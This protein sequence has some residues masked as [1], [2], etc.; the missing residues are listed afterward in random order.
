MELYWFSQT[1]WFLLVLNLLLALTVV[2]LERRDIGVTWAWLMVLFFL[3]IVGFILYLFFG[4]NLSR[5]KRYQFKE[6]EKILL[7]GVSA[8][9]QKLLD[10]E[11]EFNDPRTSRY[12]ELLHMNMVGDFSLYSQ[13]NEVTVYSDGKEKFEALLADIEQAEKYIHVQYYIWQNDRL[14]RRMIDALTEKAKQGVEVRVLYDAWGSKKIGRRF[15]RDFREAGGLA[16]PFFPSRIPFI[17]FKMNYRNHRKLVIIDGGCGYIGG[18]N[19]GD[20]YLGEVKRFGYWRDTHLRIEGTALIQ[21]HSIFLHDWSLSV[22]QTM[23]ENL[24]LTVERPFTGNVGA[25]IVSSGP[26]QSK[27]TI[28]LSYIKMMD[29]ARETIMIQTPYFIPDESMM[30]A[31]KMAILSGV[32][33]HLM[34]PKVPDHKMVYWASYSYLGELLDLGVNCYLYEKGF[35]HA[36]TI[37]VDGRLASVGT[38]NMDIRSYKLNFEVN[39][40]IYDSVKAGELE[41][42]FRKDM[43]DSEVLTL[44]KYKTRP[45]LRKALESFTRLLSPIL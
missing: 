14:G 28:K 26:D 38:A 33:V 11:L 24:F 17:N 21:M 20:E 4:Q 19:V 36:K 43:D 7:P 3:P 6:Q 40:I 41:A 13:D 5:G 9:R 34:I 10:G 44:E 27:E 12:R 1:P 16:A 23:P 35:L 29:E 18:F 31:L 25:Q 2:F 42:L 45:L 30:T 15:L 32:E 39:A 22:R 37:V 8:Q